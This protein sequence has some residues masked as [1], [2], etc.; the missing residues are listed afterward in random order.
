M[1]FTQIVSVKPGPDSQLGKHYCRIRR[2]S[3][4]GRVRSL[5]FGVCV[6]PWKC[7]ILAQPVNYTWRYHTVKIDFVH[8]CYLQKAIIKILI[9]TRASAIASTCE[10]AL[11]TRLRPGRL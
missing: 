5:Y 8:K 1:F 4:Y 2:F 3:A 7:K 6:L 9:P 10:S 11:I